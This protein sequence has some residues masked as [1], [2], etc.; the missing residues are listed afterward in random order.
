MSRINPGMYVRDCER[1]AILIR[2]AE[3]C[4]RAGSPFPRAAVIAA[5]L[6]VAPCR[7][8]ELVARLERE[9]RLVFARYGGRKWPLPM[10]EEPNQLQLDLVRVDA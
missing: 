9:G 4:M 5:G 1:D 7:A 2:L 10:P 8:S 6:G 3:A